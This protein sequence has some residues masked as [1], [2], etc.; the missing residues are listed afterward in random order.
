MNR[1]QLVA[2]ASAFALTR[3]AQPQT[4]L[5]SGEPVLDTPRIFPYDTLPVKKNGNLSE[6][7]PVLRG[8]LV[9]GETIEIHESTM[10]PGGKPNPPHQH[11]PS[12]IILVR[13]GTI[14]FEHDGKSEQVG[15]GGVIFVASET[16]HTLRNAGPGPAHYFVIVIGRESANQLA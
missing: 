5:P 6:T 1:R 3:P 4:V 12:D 9:T 11:R 7:R 2:A 13:E 10:A 15:P 14:A 8:A 16:M